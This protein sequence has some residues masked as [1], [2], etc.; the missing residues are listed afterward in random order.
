MER[1]KGNNFFEECCSLQ[2]DE[3]SIF[4]IHLSIV[5]GKNIV[6]SDHQAKLVEIK[7]E[8]EKL[9]PQS[10]NTKP[11]M[12]HKKQVDPFQIKHKE[13]KSHK[14]SVCDYSCTQK[15]DLKRHIDAIHENKKPHK[16]SICDQSFSLKDSL[17]K[18]IEFVHEKVKPHIPQFVDTAVL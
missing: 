10:K 13:S 7:V 5:H 4:D 11:N 2:F 14:C 9:M 15:Q 1:I 3:K 6:Q 8:N 16:C 18:H 12:N 17:N